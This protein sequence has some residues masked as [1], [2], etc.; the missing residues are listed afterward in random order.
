M[1]PLTATTDGRPPAQGGGSL[2]DALVGLGILLGALSLVEL[3]IPSTTRGVLGSLLDGALVAVFTVT[4]LLAWYRRPHNPTGRLMVVTALAVWAA[5]TQDDVIVAL[6]TVGTLLAGL[7]FALLLHLLLGFPS[8]RLPGRA[9]RVTVVVGYLVA[10]VPQ[11]VKVLAPDAEDVAWAVQ[12]ALGVGALLVTISLSARRLARV[13]AV[14]RRR[15]LP[16]VGYGCMALAVIAVTIV[17]LHYGPGP[18]LED[19]AMVVQLVMLGG[20]PVAFLIG[21]TFG[22]FGRAGESAEVARGIAAASAEPA[23]LDALVSRALGDPRAQVLWAT[24]DGEGLVDSEGRRVDGAD[25][26]GWWPI[27]PDGMRAGALRYDPDLTA[28][29][30]LVATVAA[31]LGVAMDNRRLVVDL[32]SAVQRLHLAAEELR[33]SRRRVV[34]A[35]DAERRRIAQD[36][37]DGAQQRIVLVGMDV[38]RLARRSDDAGFVRAE[39]L[40]VAELCGTLL[41]ELR[42]LVQGIMPSRLRDHGLEAAVATLAG[43]VP[44]PVRVTVREPLPRMDATVES[45]GYF[46]VAE[47]L[48]NAVKHAGAR[49]VVVVLD[50]ADGWLRIKVSDDGRAADPTGIEAG[51]GLRSLTDRVETLGGTLSVEATSLGTTV[52]ARVPTR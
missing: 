44:L 47:A 14:E 35:A 9:A 34:V 30:S 33:L 25:G 42:D 36:L 29:L 18:A 10:L 3:A 19:V 13:P 8:G 2:R 32:R 28:D 48:T 49:G 23:L 26:R 17:V 6:R 27:G 7:P 5:G 31:P 37:H 16:F 15:L 20:F 50:D 43:E 12:G 11:V 51:F 39:A 52:R 46:V 4:G 45:T 40:R 38:Q 1:T 22:A 24:G 41:D 21:L